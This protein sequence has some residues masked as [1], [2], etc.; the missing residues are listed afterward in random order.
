MNRKGVKLYVNDGNTTLQERAENEPAVVIKGLAFKPLEVLNYVDG[1]LMNEG[2]TGA[3]YREYGVYNSER[4]DS[5][6][7][8]VSPDEATVVEEAVKACREV[9]KAN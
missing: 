2:K 6:T 4:I 1:K 5:T 7:L 3:E 9:A 8:K